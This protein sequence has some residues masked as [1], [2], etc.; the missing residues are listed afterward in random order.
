[1]KSDWLE[2]H[3]IDAIDGALNEA[4]RKRFEKEL[5][6]DP[7]AGKRF[8]ELR[9]IA[10]MARQAPEVDEP[11][12]FTA[13][14][15]DRIRGVRHPWWIRL[16]YFL[17]RPREVRI[18]ILGALSGA[19]ALAVAVAVW[20][21]VLGQVEPGRLPAAPV[22]PKQYVMRFTYNDPN[23]R[24]VYVAGSFNNWQKEQVPLVDQ[25]GRGSWVAV[26]PMK[27][28]VYE[29]MFFVDGRW[30]ADDHALRYKDDGFGRKNAILELG[31]GN[32]A[33]I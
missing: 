1:M 26:V 16:W 22:V 14:V 4:D 3:F 8:E 17:I 13:G 30:V 33:S 2:D 18:N 29:Y 15:M 5:S 21:S 19:A 9:R 20:V 12:D 31:N 23:A 24:Q 27:P 28:G 10:D 25:S 7:E 32:E 6:Q 11:F